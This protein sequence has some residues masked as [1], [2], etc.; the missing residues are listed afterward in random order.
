MAPVVIE[1]RPG[2]GTLIGATEVVKAEPDGYTLLLGST[3]SHIIAPVIAP[4]APYDPLKD[5]ATIAIISASATSI[6]VNPA[7]RSSR[8][9]S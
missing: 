7:Y 1:N 4:R 5:L 3:S 9:R 2:A 6:V 8:C